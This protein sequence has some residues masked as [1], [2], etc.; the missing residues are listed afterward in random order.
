MSITLYHIKMAYNVH[1]VFKK[2]L[3][4]N[5]RNIFNVES[6]NNIVNYYLFVKKHFSLWK[7]VSI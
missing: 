4:Y 7:I 1:D 3:A 6:E 5:K 2:K